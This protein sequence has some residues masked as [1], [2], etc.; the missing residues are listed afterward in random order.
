MSLAALLPLA[1][2]GGVLPGPDDEPVD[3]PAV[4]APSD[5]PVPVP[6]APRVGA[7]GI[8]NYLTGEPVPNERVLAVKIDNT[9]A[10][11]PQ[12]GLNEADVVY[13]VEVEGG[14]TRLLAVFQTELPARIGPV[15]SGRTSDVTI[16]GNYGPVALAFAG[17]NSGVVRELSAT[18]LQL[19]SLAGGSEGFR[20]DPG[21]RGP[22]DVIGDGAAL[23]ARAPGS[24]IAQ[25]VGF[26]FGPVPDGGRPVAGASYSWPA[27]TA[28]FAWSDAEDAWVQ[29]R[30]G[31]TALDEAGDPVTARTVVFMDVPV[32]PTRYVDVNG[33][34]SPEVRPVGSGAVTVLRDGRAFPGRWSRDAPAAPTTFTDEAGEELAFDVGNVWVVLMRE[35]D[36]P[37]L[38]GG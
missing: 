14:S 1:A 37:T 2:C 4:T 11:L 31:E 28:E 10:A 19:V 27:S 29:R 24:G 8:D 26:R 9:S 38:T 13:V 15:R 30:G 3:Q 20:R 12:A 22:Y 6:S 23:L 32:L 25:D 16:L 35:G 36:T 21:R 5:L 33:A 18:S 17:A 34:R 7:A